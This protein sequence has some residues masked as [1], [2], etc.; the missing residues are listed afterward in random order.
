MAVKFSLSGN[1]QY[2]VATPV[3]Q[4]PLDL[5]LQLIERAELDIT[6]LS[7][8]H[9][10]DQYLSYIEELPE[11]SAEEVSGFLVIAAK[12]IQIKSESLLPRPPTRDTGEEDPG[13]QLARQ[14]RLYRQFKSVAKSLDELQKLDKRA[15]TS[16]APVPEL[17]GKLQ[18]TGI[19]KSD[20]AAAFLEVMTRIPEEPVSLD[21]AITPPK[22]TIRQKVKLVTD[23]L[24]QFG[25]SSFRRL[26]GERSTREEIGVT[27]LALLELVKLHFIEVSQE[28]LFADIQIQASQ[29]W[30]GIEDIEFEFGE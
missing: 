26:L 16:L 29:E 7:L 6:K 19:D 11:L 15:Y 18:L 13:E 8:A 24:R 4:G 9:V 30:E 2:Q 3:Y 27:F 28:D 17:E 25:R 21:T 5:L 23:Q 1:D 20:L 10:T 22:V 12:L 14:L